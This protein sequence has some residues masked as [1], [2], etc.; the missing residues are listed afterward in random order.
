MTAKRKNIHRK[1]PIISVVPDPK[2]EPRGL[3]RLGPTD[4]LPPAWQFNILDFEG[5]W[6][7]DNVDVDSLKNIIL[8]HLADIEKINWAQMG[9][10]GS[11]PISID[12]LIPD[13]RKRLRRL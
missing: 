8:P 9:Q 2:K 7:W 3:N 4:D 5:R 12:K 1:K 6:G 11:H 13:A 10:T